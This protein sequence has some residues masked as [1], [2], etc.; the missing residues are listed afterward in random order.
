MPEIRIEGALSSFYSTLLRL[1]NNQ[2]AHIQPNVVH[3]IESEI[4]EHALDGTE[5]TGILLGRTEADGR[6]IIIEE[7]APV[8]GVPEGNSAAYKYA[9][10][11]VFSV[12]R[13]ASGK[14]MQP[15]GLYRSLTDRASPSLD[16]ADAL[17]FE[18]HF[19]HPE[20]LF[21]LINSFGHATLLYRGNETICPSVDQK[22]RRLSLATN[23]DSTALVTLVRS[24]T[25]SQWQ[26][27]GSASDT[28]APCDAPIV[29]VRVSM[30]LRKH[31]WL[32]T[33]STAVVLLAL[34]NLKGPISKTL[35]LEH[36]SVDRPEESESPELRVERVG[37][38]WRV[39][40][41]RNA[42]IVQTASSRMLKKGAL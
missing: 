11:R 39:T 9:V 2:C 27:S 4:K 16:E 38:Q 14:R 3:G 15:V 24:T 40:W 42:R 26:H 5:V 34:S 1:S 30:W 8:H 6:Q 19:R 17:L 32:V 31:A 12:W 21:L 23:L 13:R 20:G 10:V 29:P 33:A 7:Y 37:L 22:V 28:I 35:T 41:N 18:H 36:A 25:S